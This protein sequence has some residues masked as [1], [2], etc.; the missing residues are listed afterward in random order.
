MNA[1]TQEVYSRAPN[2][3]ALDS[4]AAFANLLSIMK[5]LI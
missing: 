1:S 5:P 3:T 4:I 2:A